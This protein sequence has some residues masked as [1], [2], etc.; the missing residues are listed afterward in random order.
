MSM[1]NK[2]I[3]VYLP[4]LPGPVSLQLKRFLLFF[5]LTGLELAYG[6]LGAAFQLT[7]TIILVLAIFTIVY[8]QIPALIFT[9]GYSFIISAIL[10]IFIILFN[11]GILGHKY[12][13]FYFSLVIAIINIFVKIVYGLANVQIAKTLNN[14]P[15]LPF[16]VDNI[17]NFPRGNS[18]NG[19]NAGGNQAPQSHY[20]N[21]QMPP[22]HTYQTNTIYTVKQYNE[23]QSNEV[24]SL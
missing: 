3:S 7:S 17:F 24:G 22:Q 13:Q 14:E 11:W 9:L 15:P 6:W 20:T 19:Q 18:G 2:G 8:P 1:S 5:F 21:N 10:D 23:T 16:N 4:N 12:W